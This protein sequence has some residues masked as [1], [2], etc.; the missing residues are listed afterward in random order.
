MTLWD[1]AMVT[2]EGIEMKQEASKATR[3]VESGERRRKERKKEDDD[4][5]EIA[6][7]RVWANRQSGVVQQPTHA[8]CGASLGRGSSACA[9]LNYYLR[10]PSLVPLIASDNYNSIPSSHDSIHCG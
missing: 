6:R 2:D 8:G 10:R 1:C 3:K 9:V 7:A 5:E 4:G